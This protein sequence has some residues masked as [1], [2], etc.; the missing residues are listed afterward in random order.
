MATTILSYIRPSALSVK[1]AGATP[2]AA[3]ESTVQASLADVSTIHHLL[4]KPPPLVTF[5][6]PIP[7]I[8]RLILVAYLVYAIVV[9]I[10]PINLIIAIVGTFLMTWRAPWARTI[11]HILLS[12]GWIRFATKRI[13][14]LATGTVI[15]EDSIQPIDKSDSLSIPKPSSADKRVGAAAA[16]TSTGE[17]EI[18]EDVPPP[19]SLRFRFIVHENQRWWMG[20]DWTAALLPN[21]RA[22]WTSAP[23]GLKPVPPPMGITLPPTTTVYLPVSSSGRGK[24]SLPF[25]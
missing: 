17:L 6:L 24:V 19:S 16:P 12:N 22:S 1:D 21:E 23:P 7:S 5:Q 15:T 18:P 4:P 14:G 2:E 8:V 20:L 25:T 3:T 11:R 9:F 10:L 13:W